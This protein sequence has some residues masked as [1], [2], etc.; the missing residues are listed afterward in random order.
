MQ[1]H[2]SIER[3][4]L[5]SGSRLPDDDGGGLFNGGPG[6]HSWGEGH[7][8]LLVR[9]KVDEL[10][11]RMTEI[12]NFTEVLPTPDGNAL[13]V[14]GGE[15][16]AEGGPLKVGLGPAGSGHFFDRVRKRAKVNGDLG[17][18]Q[19]GLSAKILTRKSPKR[20]NLNPKL[21]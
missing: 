7:H 14:E 20:V 1:G 16:G 2:F 10:N 4:L 17:E 6:V 3:S 19:Q 13:G 21:F 15:V 9:R 5:D 12:R 11:S 8:V 18:Q